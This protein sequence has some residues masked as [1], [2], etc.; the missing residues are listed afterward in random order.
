VDGLNIY[1]AGDHAGWREGEKEGF[2]REI[3]YLAQHITELDLAFLNVTGC[4]A[5]GKEPLKE[6]TLYTLARLKPRIMIPTHAGDREYV[7]REA[8]EEAVR[9][10]ITIPVVRPENRGD[11]LIYRNGQIDQAIALGEV[12]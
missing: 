6:G 10:G 9:E 4:H 7:Y 12:R 1:H 5:H 3:D 11:W 8:A 2:T